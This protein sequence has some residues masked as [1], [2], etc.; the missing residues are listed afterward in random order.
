MIFNTDETAEAIAKAGEHCFRPLTGIMI[1]NNLGK[2]NEGVLL[3]KLFPSPY[4]DYD[5]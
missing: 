4:G 2:Y 5:F 1:F 3:Y